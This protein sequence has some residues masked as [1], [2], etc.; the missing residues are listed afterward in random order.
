MTRKIKG[1]ESEAVAVFAC[2]FEDKE[3]NDNPKGIRKRIGM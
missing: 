1:P 2:A 3:H